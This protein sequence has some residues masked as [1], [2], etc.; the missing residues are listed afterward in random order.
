MPAQRLPGSAVPAATMLL[1]TAGAV[2][3]DHTGAVFDSA[4]ATATAAVLLL[5]AGLPHGGFDLALLR[6]AA[7]PGAGPGLV[8]IIALYLGCAGLMYLLWVLQPVAA[9]LAFLAMALLHFAEDWQDQGSALGGAGISAALLTAPTWRNADAL[10]ALLVTLTGSPDALAIS[11]G[12]AMLAPLALLLAG[13]GIV[14]LRRKGQT[15]LVVAATASLGAMLLL[16]PVVGFALFFGLV[17]SPLQ[18]REHA[19]RLGLRGFRQWGAIVMPISFGGL[20]IALAILA[21]NRGMALPANIFAS[22]FMALSVLTV[23]HMLV[24]LLVR[25]LQTPRLAPAAK[26]QYY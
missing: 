3:I 12:M 5:L 10:G 7:I 20:G 21:G 22:S 4:A 18:F 25:R 17:H 1:A 6:R 13:L 23:P 24:P 19:G 14:R 15:R 26:G 9:L 11:D 2:V 16:P 8:T